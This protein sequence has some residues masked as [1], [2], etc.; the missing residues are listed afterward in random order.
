LHKTI[1]TAA[2]AYGIAVSKPFWIRLICIPKV[3]RNDSK[4][5]G[6]KKNSKRPLNPIPI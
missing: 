1:P 6:K 3:L 4:T 2:N 5:L